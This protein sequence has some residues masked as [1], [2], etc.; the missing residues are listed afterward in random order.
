MRGKGGRQGESMWRQTEGRPG[1]R[2]SRAEGGREEHLDVVS[3]QQIS[4][5][6]VEP[7][8]FAFRVDA[9]HFEDRTAG[10]A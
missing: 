5:L 3:S 8:G 2:E 1:S 7:A 9:E 6:N 10:G 4:S